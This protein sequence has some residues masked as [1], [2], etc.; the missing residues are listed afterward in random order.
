MIIKLQL[1]NTIVVASRRARSAL[2]AMPSGL[3]SVGFGWGGVAG[4]EE[5]VDLFILACSMLGPIGV[6]E[7]HDLVMIST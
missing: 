1:K 7:T 2:L 3:S 6:L 5:A 4:G